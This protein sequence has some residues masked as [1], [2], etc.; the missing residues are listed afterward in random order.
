MPRR[1]PP[2]IADSLL[3]QLLAGADAKTA[4]EADGL[5]DHLKT[6]LAERALAAWQARPLE[7]VYPLVFF[8]ALRVMIRDEGTVRNKAGRSRPAAHG[9]LDSPPW[10][11]R[12]AR[13]ARTPAAPRSRPA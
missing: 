1:K 6:A 12:N 2:V 7:A 5:L 4:F 8:D 9:I 13:H 3:D 10:T 11:A